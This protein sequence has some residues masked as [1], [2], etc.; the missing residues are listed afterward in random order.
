MPQRTRNFNISSFTRRDFVGLRNA[1]YKMKE[2]FKLRM[3]SCTGIG[4]IYYRPGYCKHR[5]GSV[6]DSPVTTE[7]LLSGRR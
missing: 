3:Y 5:R 7:G 6:L 2:I 4:T 1:A